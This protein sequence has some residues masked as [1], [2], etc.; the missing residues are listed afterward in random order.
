DAGGAKGTGAGAAMAAAAAAAAGMPAGAGSA[1]AATVPPGP[2]GGKPLAYT[3]F[4]PLPGNV[5][6]APLTPKEKI[7]QTSSQYLSTIEGI[8]SAAEQ[9]RPKAKGA[10]EV[11]FNTAG[12]NIFQVAH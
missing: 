10:G 8:L 3:K 2:G 4:Q 11:L 1:S 6:S 5:P 7:A 9:P 12:T